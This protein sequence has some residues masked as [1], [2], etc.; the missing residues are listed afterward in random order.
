MRETTLAR[1][2]LISVVVPV[3][4]E[5]KTVAPF[6]DAIVPHLEHLPTSW[7]VVFVNDGSSD[8]T[9]DRIMDLAAEES[10]V[11]IIDLSRNFGKEAALTAGLDNAQGD[12]TIIM[13]ADLQDPPHLIGEMVSRWAE[14]FDV[15]LA[16]R[17]SRRSDT[18]LKRT[19]AATFYRIYNRISAIEATPNVSD[20]RLMDKRVVEALAALPERVRF[21]KGLFAWVGFRSTVITFQRPPRHSGESKFSYWKLW[22][23][24]LDGLTSFSTIPL[25]IWSYLG[26][27]IALLSFLY[28]SWIISRTLIFGV[29][30]PGYASMLTAILFLGG[31]QLLG[32]GI[33][34]EYLGRTYLEAKQRPIYLI[35]Q[36]YGFGPRGEAPRLSAHEREKPI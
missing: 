34:G 3:Y 28:G 9:F 11:R 27:C 21:M 12:A 26:T 31:L 6:L 17:D 33:L 19:T 25:R 20:C 22:N 13:D 30:V 29:D 10:R 32:I 35:R 15:V 16:K 2:V 36:L 5:E 18:L 1:S 24:A 4:N 7:E 23:F 8:G 14:G